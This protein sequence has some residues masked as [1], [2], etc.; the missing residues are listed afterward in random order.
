MTEAVCLLSCANVGGW[1][2]L[3]ILLMS[4]M[5]LEVNAG[6]GAGV[7]V[8]AVVVTKIKIVYDYNTDYNSKNT[9]CFYSK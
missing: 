8:A 7:D 9:Q 6:V 4:A 5:G 2:L 1:N 3:N